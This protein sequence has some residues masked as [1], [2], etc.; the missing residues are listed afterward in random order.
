MAEDSLTSHGRLLPVDR[1]RPGRLNGFSLEE[2]A[3]EI[4][5]RL[6]S[7][8]ARVQDDGTLA[9]FLL[10]VAD[11]LQVAVDVPANRCSTR[12][13]RD[14][15]VNMSLGATNWPWRGGP[16]VEL[17]CGSVHPWG[18]VFGAVLS[19]ASSGVAIDLDEPQDPSLSARLMFLHAVGAIGAPNAFLPSF[20]G[21]DVLENLQGINLEQLYRGDI[22][23]LAGRVEF[24]RASAASTGLP[25]GHAYC[26]TSS[27]FLEHVPDVRSVLAEM[28]RITAVGHRGVHSIDGADHRVYSQDVHPLA[29]LQERGGEGSMHY[30]SNRVRPLDFEPLFEEAGFVVERIE[31]H[32]RTTTTEAQRARFVEPWASMEPERL[33]V[34]SATLYVRRR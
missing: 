34:L 10:K 31:P 32:I 4:Y 23:G 13:L 30:G 15:L 19:G 21:N 24:R 3:S 8:S 16:I 28:A 25:D 33:S 1:P 11:R 17:G 29:F 12:H 14:H 22:G 27:S 26:T 2:L 7:D 9:E 18:V 20:E 5:G 6:G